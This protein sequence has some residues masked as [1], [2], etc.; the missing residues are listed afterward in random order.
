LTDFLQAYET[1]DETLG[2]DDLTY[3]LEGSDPKAFL[4]V[5]GGIAIERRRFVHWRGGESNVLVRKP[6]RKR[7]RPAERPGTDDDPVRSSSYQNAMVGSISRCRCVGDVINIE[8]G[9]G[10]KLPERIL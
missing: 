8:T 1:T 4:T 10:A 9:K 6:G 3:R 2:R 5:F 7:G